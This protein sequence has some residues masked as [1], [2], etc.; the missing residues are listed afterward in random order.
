VTNDFLSYGPTGAWSYC[1]YVMHMPVFIIYAVLLH[2]PAV[3]SLLPPCLSEIAAIPLVHMPAVMT[4]LL[5]VSAA[6]AH[7]VEGPARR[8]LLSASGRDERP[9]G[10]GRAP[11]LDPRG[12]CKAAPLV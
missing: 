3:W 9:T 5:L 12:S 4:T 10:Q 7:L 8:A 1:T 11:Q 2:G 6:S